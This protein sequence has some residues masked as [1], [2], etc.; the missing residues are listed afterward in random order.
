ME[1][2]WLHRLAILLAVCTLLLV[3]TG[4]SVTSTEASSDY[5]HRIIANA[6]GL[7]TLVTAIALWRLETRRWMGVLGGCALLIV[8]A[9]MSFSSGTKLAAIL[10]A[11][12]AQ[13][14]FATT[15]AIAV[16]TSPS[17]RRDPVLLEDSG[18]PSIRSM[19]VSAPILV[20]IQLVL[21]AGY[22]HKAFGM[23]PHVTGAIFV[24]GFLLL[25]SVFVVSQFATHSSLQRSAWV[26]MGITA[27]QV[28]LGIAAYVARL[29]NASTMVLLTVAHVATGALTMAATATLSVQI[30]RNVRPQ[31]K[32]ASGTLPAVS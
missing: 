23:L 12:L 19:A 31:A 32:V 14:F 1:H 15:V 7:L 8:L 24:A 5:G 3:I 25:I 30:F 2:P 16:C 29:S 27:V 11:C 10:H 28:I 22:R 9:Q 21:G 17:W 18:W 20:V 4:A 26:L 6:V 13:L